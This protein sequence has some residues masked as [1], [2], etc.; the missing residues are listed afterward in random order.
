MGPNADV[1]ARC[2]IPIAAITANSRDLRRGLIKMHD[3]RLMGFGGRIGAGYRDV[4]RAID[5]DRCMHHRSGKVA[6][7]AIAGAVVTGTEHA[8]DGPERADVSA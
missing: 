1:S 5:R 6:I 8:M 3:I 2:S 7:A 4:D